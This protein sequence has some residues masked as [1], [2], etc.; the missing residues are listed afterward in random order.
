MT[1]TGYYTQADK[2]QDIASSLIS[3]IFRSVAFPVFSKVQDDLQRLNGFAGSNVRAIA[4]FIFPIMLLMVV[5]RIR[6]YRSC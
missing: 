4:F 3:N 2:Y 1:Q 5:V 6:S